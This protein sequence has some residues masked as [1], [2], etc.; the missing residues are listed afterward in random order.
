M[1]KF[2]ENLF[3][4]DQR[5]GVARL[6][7]CCAI[8]HHIIWGRLMAYKSLVTFVSS[9]AGL[10]DLLQASVQLA[11]RFGAHLDV[12]CLGIDNTQSLGFYA[13]AP[14]IIYQE[15]LDQARDRANALEQEAQNILRNAAIRWGTDT[16]VL[17]LGAVGAHVSLKARYSDLVV[18]PLP[19]AEGSGPEAEIIVEAALF[20]ASAPVL[21]LPEGCRDLPEFSKIVL[22]WNQS[23]E[24]MRAARAALPVLTGADLVNI[25]VIDPSPNSLERSDP[26]GTLAQFLTRHGAMVDVSVIAKTLPRTS[27]VLQRHAREQSAKMIVIGAY[28]HS[29]LRQAILGGTTRSLLETTSIPVFMAR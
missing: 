28:S 6:A 20:D 11:Q 10:T 5:E 29:R 23:D 14:A 8:S 13:G 15:A 19:Y 21:I 25:V 17:T 26:G 24:A 1:S 22:A 16:A 12:C 7:D 4:P 2:Y 3:A 27:E 18:L 9:D